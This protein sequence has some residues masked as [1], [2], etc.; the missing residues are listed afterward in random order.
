M[1]SPFFLHKRTPSRHTTSTP[2]DKNS[3]SAPPTNATLLTP[4]KPLTPSFHQKKDR[5]IR[6]HKKQKP[7]NITHAFST[8]KKKKT[9]PISPPQTFPKLFSH[10]F[11]FF[12]A[13][14]FSIPTQRSQHS[15]SP[16]PQHTLTPTPQPRNLTHAHLPTDYPKTSHRNRHQASIDGLDTPRLYTTPPDS[17]TRL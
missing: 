11:F 12:F 15:H 4:T 6:D 3:Q 13:T 14:I 8:R 10:N 17:R 16:P 1:S 7:S 9:Q 2:R 5:P